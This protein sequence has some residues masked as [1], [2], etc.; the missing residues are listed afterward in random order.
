MND[1]YDALQQSIYDY[2]HVNELNPRKKQR[3]METYAKY[4]Y[5]YETV[6]NLLI[7]DE[8]DSD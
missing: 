2:V 5:D 1:L 4:V 8:E 7:E 6:A 3:I